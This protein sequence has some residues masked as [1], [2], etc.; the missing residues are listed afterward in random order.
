M[1]NQ[2]SQLSATHLEPGMHT[3]AELQ[4]PANSSD[5]KSRDEYRLEVPN[6]RKLLPN[7]SIELNLLGLD[8]APS[9]KLELRVDQP[10]KQILLSRLESQTKRSFGSIKLPS[11][12]PLL[13][14]TRGFEP[15]KS[16]GPATASQTARLGATAEHSRFFGDLEDNPENLIKFRNSQT[17]TDRA[18][19]SKGFKEGV[20]RVEKILSQASLAGRGATHKRMVH[21]QSVKLLDQPKSIEQMKALKT[22]LSN[23]NRQEMQALEKKCLDLAR[24]LNQV[25]DRVTHKEKHFGQLTEQLQRMEAEVAGL[26][27]QKS[28]ETAISLREKLLR[29][30]DSL[31]SEKQTERRM[32]RIIDIC[33][34]SKSQ[35]EE[36]LRKLSFYASNLQKCIR[37]QDHQIKDIKREGIK[38][39]RRLVDLETHSKAEKDRRDQIMIDIQET[40][41]TDKVIKMHLASTD[42]I[43]RE[44]VVEKRKEIQEKVE[45]RIRNDDHQKKE[46]EVLRKNIEV[47]EELDKLKKDYSKYSR[48]LEKGVGGEDWDQKPEFIKLLANYQQTKS[49]E[50]ELLQKA[51]VLKETKSKNALLQ[52]KLKQLEQAKQV[53]IQLETDPEYLENQERKLL[54]SI[55]T[56][57]QRVALS[58]PRSP[59]PPP[60]GSRCRE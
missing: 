29:I 32:A 57:K 54:L 49:L 31:R 1:Q 3:T 19:L 12:N 9:E 52:Q 44:S 51:F 6:K 37:E 30:E 47:Q 23:Q 33:T 4:P 38:Q 35:N 26:E 46:E 48:L 11:K 20:E 17:Q 55:E 25:K 24:A 40:L 60:P 59:L 53:L 16:T 45:E 13:K 22:S 2:V 43:I 8:D 39:E 42:G 27:T 36:W 41:D 34:I 50:A 28:G 18:P 15:L 10:Q 7:P 14:T 5:S 56:E 58:D 21:E